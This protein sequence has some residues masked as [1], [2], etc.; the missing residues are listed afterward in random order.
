MDMAPSEMSFKIWN[1][2]WNGRSRT[3]VKPALPMMSSAKIS[4]K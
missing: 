2:S 1:C 3:V 4:R